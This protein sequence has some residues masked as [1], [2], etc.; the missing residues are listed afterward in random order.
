MARFALIAFGCDLPPFPAYPPS[1]RHH[2]HCPQPHWVQLIHPDDGTTGP[3]QSGQRPTRRI[4]GS[5]FGTLSSVGGVWEDWREYATARLRRFRFLF[6][7]YY[8]IY[9][10]AHFRQECFAAANSSP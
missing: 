6:G 10:E 4:V 2:P 3:E 5:S 1:R 8:R 7:F 9:P